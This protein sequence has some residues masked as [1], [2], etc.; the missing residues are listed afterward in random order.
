MWQRPYSAQN[1]LREGPGGL[2]PEGVPGGLDPLQ[3]A[4]AA[5]RQS[6]EPLLVCAACGA[7]ITRPDAAIEVN[8]AHAHT[9]LNPAGEIYRIRCFAS[10]P[11]ALPVGEESD[12]WTWFAGQLWQACICRSCFEHLGWRFSGGGAAFFGLIHERIVDAG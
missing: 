12:Y 9:F 1:C 5:A 4:G 11:G 8:G 7:A 2:P 6:D 10:A 3:Q